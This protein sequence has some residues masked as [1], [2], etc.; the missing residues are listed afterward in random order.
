MASV[1]EPDPINKGKPVP[2]ELIKW[3]KENIDSP[4]Q[5]QAAIS[6]INA[7]DQFGRQKYGQPLMT[8]DGRDTIEDSKQ[9][10]GDLI[11]YIMKAKLN[12]EDLTPIRRLLPVLIKLLK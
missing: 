5:R 12:G 10:L 2:T 6:L 1:P 3:I 9:E 7:R 8:E 4:E 11:Q